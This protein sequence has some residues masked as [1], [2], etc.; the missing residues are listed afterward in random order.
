VTDHPLRSATDHCLGEPLPHQQANRARAPP[1]ASL[2]TLSPA[3][4]ATGISCG[5]SPAFAGVSPSVGQVA[6]VL[7]TR[8]PCAGF[9]Y[10]YEKLR[11][12][13]ACVKHAASVR[14]E[15]GSNSRLNWLHRK[16]AP[17]TKNPAYAGTFVLFTCLLNEL[18]VSL[19]STHRTER[20]LARL[21]QLSKNRPPVQQAGYGAIG[22]FS[23]ARRIVKR[24]GKL[25]WPPR[26]FPQP[27]S[28]AAT[29]RESTRPQHFLLPQANALLCARWGYN[30]RERSR[31]PSA[32]ASFLM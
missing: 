16:Q 26:A 18:F 22:E 29:E 4:E 20:V 21:I 8:A 3:A 11:T 5:I 27:P 9:P 14:S 30:T 7:L 32:S 25:N 12:R 10:C 24:Y 6:H 17:K 19:D 1:T 31:Q 23:R 13:L 2:R 28:M 15:P